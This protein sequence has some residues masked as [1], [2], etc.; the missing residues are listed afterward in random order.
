MSDNP[1]LILFAI[2]LSTLTM[3]FY[4][5]SMFESM[6]YENSFVGKPVGYEIIP[7]I[8]NVKYTGNMICFVTRI[9]FAS[10][11]REKECFLDTQRSYRQEDAMTFATF[12]YK[13]DTNYTLHYDANNFCSTEK[14]IYVRAKSF[15]FVFFMTFG[16]LAILS[17]KMFM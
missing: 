11:N 2:I 13:P 16:M 4:P 10:E 6:H 15:L 5:Y 14:K 9:K 12:H 8:C 3:V 17:E 7:Q 1:G